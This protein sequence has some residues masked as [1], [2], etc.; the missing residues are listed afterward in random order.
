[1]SQKKFNVYFYL[2]SIAISAIIY[3]IKHIFGTVK[4]PQA[5]FSII[6]TSEEKKLANL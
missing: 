4:L 1:M 5:W 6:L 2:R 3:K